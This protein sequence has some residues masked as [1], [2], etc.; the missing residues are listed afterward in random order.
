[1]NLQQTT[2]SVQDLLYTLGTSLERF[3]GANGLH[4]LVTTGKLSLLSL[5]GVF[6]RTRDEEYEK[7]SAAVNETRRCLLQLVD[8]F[9]GITE[10]TE[11][12]ARKID[13]LL[14][15]LEQFHRCCDMEVD[16]RANAGDSDAPQVGQ[17]FRQIREASS[18]LKRFL[19]DFSASKTTCVDVTRTAI[20][21]IEKVNADTSCNVAAALTDFDRQRRR[22]Q[23]KENEMMHAMSRATSRED[24][25]VRY[26]ELNC[27]KESEALESLGRKYI[28]S[29]G[30]AMTATHFALEQSS[31]TGWASSNVFFVQLGQLFSEL[32][33]IGKAIAASLLSIKNS[34]KV[35]HQLSE[36]KRRILREQRAAAAAAGVATNIET[37]LFNGGAGVSSGASSLLAAPSPADPSARV[38]LPTE[39]QGRGSVNLDDLFH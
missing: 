28:D 21:E 37:N 2:R 23:M 17:Y 5:F 30:N 38:S 14:G 6:E 31:M 19:G 8:D 7:R 33:A 9:E 10:S 39:G 25:A 24:P 22:L 16:G 32:S 35:S 29:L 1:M 27:V 36:E 15:T 11:K 34:Q 18:Q 26:A 3:R 13:G 4:H 12:L 20:K